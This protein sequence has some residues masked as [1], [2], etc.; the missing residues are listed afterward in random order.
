MDP[1]QKAR[2]GKTKLYVPR[3]GLGGAGLAGLYQP[4]D[5][6]ESKATIKA[7]LDKGVAYCDTAPLYGQGRSEEVMGEA[8]QGVTEP[9]Y[10]ATKV[11]YFPE[12]FDYTRDT[13]WRGF[14]RHSW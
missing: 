4:A 13:I 6:G 1:L 3:L 5:E 11:G 12:P 9:H 14:V 2:I 10:L 8:L 7:A